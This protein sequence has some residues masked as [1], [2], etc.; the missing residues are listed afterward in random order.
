[1]NNILCC[2][3]QS[4]PS[5]SYDNDDCCRWKRDET[6]SQVLHKDTGKPILQFIAVQRRD[7]GM[8]AIPG[9]ASYIWRF[10]LLHQ[11][12]GMVDPGEQISVTLKREFGEEALNTLEKTK[13]EK[14]V[15]EKDIAYL[16]QHGAEARPFPVSNCISIE[17]RYDVSDIF[18]FIE[19]MWTILETQ[20]ML[21]WRQSLITS[22]M[23]LEKVSDS[24]TSQPVS[25][26][27]DTVNY[28]V[29]VTFTHILVLCSTLSSGD[30]V[31][32]TKWFDVSISLRMF[33]SHAMLVHRAA[34]LRNAHG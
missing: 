1:M 33:S 16:F 11:L 23:I 19:V 13:E 25:T 2:R 29:I 22:T 14:E 18:R 6:G 28:F 31:N 5:D 24:L 34:R 32:A 8:W 3:I 27:V 4:K 26:T 10:F 15:I 20:T 21:G 30:G 7:S 9:V 17:A 12:Q